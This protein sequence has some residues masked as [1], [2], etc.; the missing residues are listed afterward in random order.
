MDYIRGINGV[1]S[2]LLFGLSL[3]VFCKKENNCAKASF[4]MAW[5]IYLNLLS[6]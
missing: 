6:K 1:G 5:A 4:L 2:M 3:Y